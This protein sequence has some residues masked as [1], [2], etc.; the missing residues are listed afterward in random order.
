MRTGVMH[1]EFLFQIDAGTLVGQRD[2][3]FPS[4]LGFE[5][6]F[7]LVAPRRQ[8]LA[9]DLARCA[10]AKILYDERIVVLLFALLVRPVV[11]PDLRL[12]NE[13]V[14]LA[15]VLG[16]RLP[17]TFERHKPK[18]G[19]RFARITLLILAG[20]I[21]ADQANPRIRGIPF[22]GEL[23][24]PREIADGGYCEAIHDYSL[25]V[26]WRDSR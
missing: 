18:T 15:R 12:K 13:L 8:L 2:S 26:V 9:L 20:I 25:T 7:S 23:G 5:C 17:E 16:N 21:V 6:S 3:R 19:N 22:D 14:A 1:G 4:N 11:G 24:I 10:K